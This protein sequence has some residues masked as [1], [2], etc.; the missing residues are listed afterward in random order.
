MK[1]SK[2]LSLSALVCLAVCALM[3]LLKMMMRSANHKIQVNQM[4]GMLFFIAV[5]L[6]STSQLLREEEKK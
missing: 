1:T 5:T 6:L 4:C 2:I 3:G